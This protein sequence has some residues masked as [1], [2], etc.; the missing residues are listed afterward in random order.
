LL[1]FSVLAVAV[2]WR[3]SPE[4][5][6]MAMLMGSA[7]LLVVRQRSVLLR[8]RQGLGNPVMASAAMAAFLAT[9]A[10]WLPQKQRLTDE[11]LFQSSFAQP[12]T[13]TWRF[14]EANV[15][16]GSRITWHGPRAFQYYPLFGR[17]YRLEPIRTRSDGNLSEPFFEESRQVPLVS[18]DLDRIPVDTRTFV[19]NLRSGDIDY[20]LL[21]RVGVSEKV[22]TPELL[23]TWQSQLEALQSSKR[24][25]LAFDDGQTTLWQLDGDGGEGYSTEDHETLTRN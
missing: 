19:H 12:L 20:V 22:S 11:N 2:S 9:L 10:F 1:A 16:A 24:A 5:V 3:G 23:E 18:I 8:V 4:D 14:I 7:A 13:G 6:G 25:R 17:D 21:R 15:P